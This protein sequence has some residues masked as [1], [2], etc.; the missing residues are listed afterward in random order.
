MNRKDTMNVLRL[1]GIGMLAA[2]GMACSGV[3]SDAMATDKQDKQPDSATRPPSA[4]PP[5]ALDR[6]PRPVSP[7]FRIPNTQ[8]F[9]PPHARAGS[10]VEGRAPAGSRIEGAGQT[11]TAGEDGRFRLQ[12]PADA[13]GRLP[14]RI[15]RPGRTALVLQLEIVDR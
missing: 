14:V 4:S 10:I 5:D 15:E 8:A 9:L 3:R 6:E 2:S 12:V 7:G 11:L 13:R 1:A